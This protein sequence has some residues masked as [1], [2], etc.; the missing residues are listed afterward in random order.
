MDVRCFVNVFFG[1]P[2][3]ARIIKDLHRKFFF[4]GFLLRFHALFAVFG[5]ALGAEGVVVLELVDGG[6]TGG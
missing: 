3:I 4:Y 5:F 2:Q 6:F 1:G